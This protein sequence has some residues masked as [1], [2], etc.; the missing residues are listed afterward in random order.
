M[1][2]NQNIIWAVIG[3]LVLLLFVTNCGKGGGKFFGCN[4]ADTIKVKIDTIVNHYHIDT[5]YVPEII[6]V[7]NTVYTPI[8]KTD[9]L[10]TF[11][12][13][14]KNV[15]TAEILKRFY[16]KNYYSDTLSLVRG[17]IVIQDTVTRNMITYRRLQS[18]GTDTMIVKAVT[19]QQPKRIALYFGA[20]VIGSRKDPFH[21]AGI[22]LSLKGKNDKMYSIGANVDRGGTLYGEFG[23][24]IPVRLTKK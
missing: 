16:Q 22:D 12:Y 5:V 19:L 11:E 23:L 6:G 8:Y 7:T 15:D 10:E 21:M 4:K 3:V 13:I 1:K 14:T 20:S 2:I 24:R 18:F 17:K 9:T